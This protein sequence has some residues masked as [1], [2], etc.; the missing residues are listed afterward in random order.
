LKPFDLE[1]F[2]L[3]VAKLVEKIA[4]K[5]QVR[6]LQE[7]FAKR[8]IKSEFVLCP[9]PQMSKVYELASQVAQTNNTTVLILGESGVGKEHVAQ[10]IHLQ[11]ATQIQALCRAQLCG[12]SR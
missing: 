7:T 1:A 11:S 4:L 9:S 12:D 8:A 6:Y 5:H 2:K 3:A 10:F